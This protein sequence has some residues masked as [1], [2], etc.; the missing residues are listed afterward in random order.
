MPA[1]AVERSK[2]STTGRSVP[3]RA[4]ALRAGAACLSAAA[5]GLAAMAAERLFLTP[6]RPRRRRV[7]RV[8]AGADAF[9]L[10]AAGGTVRGWRIGEGPA[11]LLVHGWGGR[12]SQL[13]PLA[14]PL[15]GAGCSLVT[16]D[17]PAH[18]LSSGRIASAVHFAAAI[19]AVA[20]R[21]S[22]RAVVAHSM[23][24][25]STALAIARGLP[26]DVA[27]FVGPA[28][29]PEPFFEHFCEAL[30]LPVGVS[31][32]VR[33]RLTARLGIAMEDLDVARVAAAARVPLLVVHDRDD[34]EV[35]WYDGAAI[36]AAWPRARLVTST[37]LGHRRIL[38]DEAVQREVS[39]FVLE[40]L[41]R[42]GTCRRLSS[43][44]ERCAGCSLADELY[45]RR[46]PLADGA[47]AVGELGERRVL[48]ALRG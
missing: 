5:P 38:R 14:E 39:A 47:S 37:G 12:A 8:L 24:A 13:L 41:A 45:H 23:G 36:A 7:P 21:V 1:H 2:I 6:P 11:V 17:A 31:T 30:R 27:V 3:W 33:R 44:G 42:C 20:T 19:E 35:A 29:S 43:N 10:T 40:H 22:P 34:R 16:F 25:A 28:R 9:A 46:G 26:L 18:G 15:L 32:G 4:R 48:R